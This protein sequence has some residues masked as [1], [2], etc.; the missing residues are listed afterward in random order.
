MQHILQEIIQNIPNFVYYTSTE[1][2][3]LL[4]SEENIYPHIKI[5]LKYDSN[6]QPKAAH[7]KWPIN[8]YTLSIYISY[9]FVLSI[10]SIFIYTIYIVYIYLYYLY[11]LFIYTI[12]LYNL[13][14][15]FIYSICLNSCNLSDEIRVRDHKSPGL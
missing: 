8:I 11:I 2:F 1:K 5:A 6:C 9:T 12:Y 10:L 4:L 3:E 7:L 13:F 14:I 15:L